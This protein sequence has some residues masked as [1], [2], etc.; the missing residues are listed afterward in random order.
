MQEQTKEMEDLCVPGYIINNSDMVK[1]ID[2]KCKAKGKFFIDFNFPH[3]DSSLYCEGKV[4]SYC[5]S[6]YINF[7]FK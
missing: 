7:Y 2:E 6:T 3:S 5:F 1:E 4:I